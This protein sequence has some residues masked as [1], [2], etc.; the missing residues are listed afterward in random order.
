VAITVGI[1][2]VP[3]FGDMAPMRERWIEAEELGADILWTC[4]HFTAMIPVSEEV[5]QQAVHSDTDRTGKNFE[6][7]TIQAAMAVTTSRARIGCIVHGNSYRNP[8][9][10]ADVARTIDHLSGG[11]FIFGMG[12][13][14]LQ[15][16]YDEYGYDYGTASS[17]LNDLVRDLPIIKS[18]LTKLKPPPLGPMPIVIASMGDKI[19]LRL[20]AEHA[21]MWQMYGPLDKMARKIEILEQHCADIGRDPAEIEYITS[22]TPQVLPDTDLDKYVALGFT[23]FYSVVWGPDWDLGELRELLA[24]KRSLASNDIAAK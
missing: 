14:Y 18:R 19:G 12:S 11:R 9:L 16:D 20:V 15:P 22:Y 21:D 6:G 5:A 1:Q 3:Q 4:D 23:H 13:G 24:W 8:N 2:L 17:R 10:M 7:T